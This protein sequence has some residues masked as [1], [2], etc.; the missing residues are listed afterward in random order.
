MAAARRAIFACLVA[1]ALAGCASVALNEAPLRIDEGRFSASINRGGTAEAVTGR[2]TLTTHAARTTLDLAS[3][4]GNTVARVEADAN[5]AT[6]TAPQAD[7]TLATFKGESPEALAESVLGLSLPVSGLAD[8]IAGRP[9][10][11]RPARVSPKDGPV[12]RIEQDGWSII[13]DERFEDTGMPRRLSLD[14]AAGANAEGSLRLR[15]VIDPQAA[16]G[17]R[18]RL[19]R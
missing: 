7:G 11:D 3:P 18:D 17:A 13:V 2:F 16:A 12:Q 19:P 9:V 4:L 10:P 6:L 8:W 1:F 5:G 14:R 15:L